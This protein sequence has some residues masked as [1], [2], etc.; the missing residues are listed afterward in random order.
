MLNNLLE[1][2][3][4]LDGGMGTMLQKAGL[5]AGIC[6]EVLNIEKPELI[7]GVHRQYVEAGS[8]IIY[9]NSFGA[10]GYKLSSEKFSPA[11][12]IGAAVKIAR[13]AIGNRDAKVALDIG[14]IGKLL[15]PNGC[16][17]FDEAY[18]LFQEQIIAGRD[19]GVDLVIIETMSDLL[20]AKAAVL[21]AQENAN[22]PV[23]VTMSYEKNGRTFVGCDPASMAVTLEGLG[24]AALGLNC[25]LRPCDLLPMMETLRRYTNLPL[26]LKA[27]AG[28]PNLNDNQYDLSAADY[29]QQLIPMI[30]LGVT[31]FGGCCGTTP[32][33]IKEIAAV[34][35]A[36]APVAREKLSF[37]SLCSAGNTIIINR[38]TIIGE[39][40]NPTGKKQ[41]KQAIL[42]HNID[43]VL[44]LGITQV[45]A[46]AKI[47]DVNVGL[48][49]V[50]EESMMR[51]VVSRLQAV[52]DAPLQIDSTDPKA[53]EAG[54]R[55]VNGKPL[56]NSVNGKQQSLLSVLPLAKKYGAAVLGLCLD[57]DGIPNKAED[58]VNIA[59]KILQAALDFGIKRED[60]YI[61]CLVLAAS[62][63]QPEVW[64]TLKAI[65]M[66]KEELNLR[67]VLGVS[68]ISFGLPN[69][70]LLN[71][72]FLTLALEAGLDLPIINPNITSM[73]NT[74]AAFEVL[75]NQ[76]KNA[77]SYVAKCGASA[78][79][80]ASTTAA[81]ENAAAAS[82]DVFYAIGHGLADEAAQCVEELL[83]E[84][85]PFAIVNEKLIPALD[86]V[87][88]SF[89]E[90][91]IYLPQL[92]QAAVSAQS[93]FAVVQKTL[94]NSGKQRLTKGKIILATVKGDIH[95]IGKNI[96]KVIL[97][98]YGYTIYDLGRDV[99]P[100][101]VLEAA[102]EYDVRLIGLSALMTTTLGSMEETIHLVKKNKK[103]SVFF[104]GG[105][106]LT[107][108]YAQKIGADYYARDA[109]QS[110]DIAKKVLG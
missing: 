109:K 106:V 46:G 8:Q 82:H 19:A 91:T 52:V 6:P 47:L 31:I 48:P 1:K 14:P 66:V 39:R 57:E 70:E 97:E 27:N 101:K 98:N 64:E 58:R 37:S 54:L 15:Q 38:P 51:T 50:D 20:E 55:I 74:V 84:C 36:R 13:R 17:P 35:K 72:T 96:V 110:V 4:L 44:N 45:E 43:Y 2:F 49:G 56:I 88:K 76:D 78:V 63:Q 24:V 83:K 25:S 68:N 34:L 29:A 92:L 16:L 7:E 53:L 11:Q 81:S 85:D 42:E 65:R 86:A 41:F 94:A 93:G 108:D 32:E 12:I 21:A 5:P 30:D 23:F 61:Y 100:E 95:D 60:V 90:G 79:E 69:R 105:A 10:N 40:I 18:S 75:S 26:I 9:T 33:Y 28:L 59:R 71:Q 73:S 89:E 3:T 62:V 103:D 77:V 67:T 87:G 104:V 22:L 107:A 99:E 80:A 102:L